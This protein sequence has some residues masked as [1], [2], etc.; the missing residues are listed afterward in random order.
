MSFFS[1]SRWRPAH[2]LLS[3]LIYWVALLAVTIGPAL[4]PILR[5]TRAN[6]KGEIAASISDGVVNLIIKET[7]RVTWTGSTHLLTAA[8]WLAVPPLILWAIWMV[9]RGVAMREAVG[10]G[11]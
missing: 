10:A 7:G 6:A 8:L 9:G 1:I 3:W 4:P 5:A 11:R 2:L